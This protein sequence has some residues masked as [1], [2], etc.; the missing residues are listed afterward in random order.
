[1][2][3]KDSEQSQAS[4]MPRKPGPR[5]GTEAARRGGLAARDRLGTEFYRQI[6]KKGGTSVR[7][8]R[9]IAFYASIG[10]AG[11][12]VTKERYGAD[13]YARIGR[14]GGLRRARDRHVTS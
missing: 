5:P 8:G 1:M 6:G 7:Q 3:A 10:S 14:Q 12:K 9:G 13:H 2:D 4:P 11:G